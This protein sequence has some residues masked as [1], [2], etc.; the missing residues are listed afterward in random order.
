MLQFVRNSYR[1]VPQS[2]CSMLTSELSFTR[3]IDRHILAFNRFD[4]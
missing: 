4:E 3:D 1:I 2:V